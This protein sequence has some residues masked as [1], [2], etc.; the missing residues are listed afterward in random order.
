MNRAPLLHP[1]PLAS[2]EAA[3]S[4]RG[5]RAR[6]W[7][8]MGAVVTALLLM[9][10]LLPG[11]RSGAQATPPPPADGTVGESDV[12]SGS[13]AEQT[14]ALQFTLRDVHGVDVNLASFKGKVILINFWATWCRPCLVEIADLVELQ[15]AH[16]DDLVVLGIN[17][18]DEFGR[19]PEFA[20]KLNVNYPIL[21]GNNRQDVEQA[22]GPIWGLPTSVIIDREGKISKKHSGI[23]T[24]E[25]FQHHIAPLL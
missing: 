8:G 6:A 10:L 21:D 18:L 16:R 24:Q 13:A 14:A 5:R 12:V 25:Q 15:A 17:V 19:V 23:A 3:T 11:P 9:V 22:Y 2:A 4:G 20:A 7:V 1:D